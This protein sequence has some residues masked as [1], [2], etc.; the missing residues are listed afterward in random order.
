MSADLDALSRAALAHNR[1]RRSRRRPRGSAAALAS[2][3]PS[4]PA[5]SGNGRLWS[6]AS[7]RERCPVCGGDSWC[8]RAR[9]GLTVLCK[10]VSSDRARVNR[11]GVEY[12]VHHTGDASERARRIERPEPLPLAADRASPEDCDRAYRAALA[13]LPLDAADREG[14]ARRGL[15]P[16]DI[17]RG[18]YRSL[19]VEGRA[20]LARAVVDAVGEEIARRVPGIVQREGDRGAWLSF[21]GSPGVL[22][23]CRDMDG[24]IAAL[25]VR[26]RDDDPR[27]GARYLYVTSAKAGGASAPSVLHVPELAREILDNAPGG[28]ARL[29]V[30]EGELKADVVSALSGDAVCSIPGVGSWRLALDAAA[31]WRPR[32]VCVALD[33]DAMRNPVVARAADSLVNALRAAGHAASLARWNPR[34]KGLDD[35]LVA[36]RRGEV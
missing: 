19:A 20:R 9:D 24:R 25:K 23:P 17:E 6:N 8:Q 15:S 22:V 1:R 31:R 21:A 7:P 32:T 16:E 18:G 5:G 2:E 26:R 36:R 10:R 34:F 4:Q 3:L 28:A 11:R 14:L 33:M 29:V 13:I 27:E 12:F 30:T 35:Y